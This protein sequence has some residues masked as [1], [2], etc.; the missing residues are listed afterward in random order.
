MTS[1]ISPDYDIE[2]VEGHCRSTTLHFMS[3]IDP[4]KRTIG[5]FEVGPLGF[6][7]WR[8]TNEKSAEA[9]AVL[10]TAL[11]LGMNLVDTADVYG[12]D[13]GGQGFGANETLL[14]Q[15][16]AETPSLRGRMVLATKGGIRPPTP[17]NSG[18][19]YLT[20][21]VHDSLN[22]LAVEFVDLFMIHR[23]DMYT[24]PAEL[25]GTLTAL[26]EAGKVR[27]FGVSNFTAHQTDALQK[28][29]DFPLVTD[30]MEYSLLR[31]DPMRDGV[32]DRCMREGVT[33]MPWSPLAGGALATGEGLD[34]DLLVKMDELAARE[35]VSRATLAVAFV[36]AHPSAPV[37]LL[38]SQSPNRLEEQ[39]QAVN[40]TLTRDDVYALFQLADGQQLP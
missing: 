19:D 14:G 4:G 9:R 38:G 37:P 8:F 23:P 33:P 24:H 5:P 29:L 39:A 13:W 36:L 3:L 35:S 21:A 26:R 22:R 20:Q 1:V 10:E 2:V 16:L 25:A 18:R 30:Q 40:V 32:L 31:L 6:G 15:L 27:E 28:H 7:C 11:D 34:A 17:Y 12:F